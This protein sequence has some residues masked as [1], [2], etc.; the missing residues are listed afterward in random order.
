MGL[1]R[2]N[3]C[4][5]FHNLKCPDRELCDMKEHTH[6]TKQLS[7][8]HTTRKLFWCTFS[9]NKTRN[10]SYSRRSRG[11]WIL[12]WASSLSSLYI[13]TLSG[14]QR[15]RPPCGKFALTLSA[16]RFFI[17]IRIRNFLV[18]SQD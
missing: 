7:H 9:C 5:W 12:F 4:L 1:R 18:L 8:W 2:L 13:K 11:N 15:L 3:L 14:F 6:M 17:T 16:D 10:G